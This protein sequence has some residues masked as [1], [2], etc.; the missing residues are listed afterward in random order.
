[1]DSAQLIHPT[2]D[3]WVNT[4]SARYPIFCRSGILNSDLAFQRYVED[5]PVLIVSHAN[6]ADLYGATIEQCLR[7]AN[8]RTVEQWLVPE[9]DA[10]KNLAQADKLWTRCLMQSYQRNLLMIALG[11]GMVGDLTGFCAS[12]YLRGVDFIQCPTTLLA[13]IDASIGGKTA[14]NHSLGK[15]LIGTFYQP[16]AVMVDPNVLHSLPAR[17]FN[18]GLAELIKYGLI[19]DADFFSWLEL[20]CVDLRHD[21]QK[22]QQAILQACKLK[23]YVVST[24]ERESN[25]RMILNFGHTVGHAI[26]NL[27]HY[28]GILHGEAVAIGMV[29]ATHLACEVNMLSYTVLERLV[30]LLR[31]IGLPVNIPPSI[32]VDAILEKIKL[33]KKN[34]NRLQ[35][36][37]LRELGSASINADVSA[38]TVKHILQQWV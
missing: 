35:W 23:A 24:D 21:S 3:L 9:G 30:T 18:A 17:E 28:Q 14:I 13:Q 12:T 36:V 32:Q 26:E 19:L 25:Q 10:H 4:D 15:N 7:R 22:C 37:L 2:P 29:V 1:M 27:M 33:D 38:R 8:A 20:N 31:S 16:L 6:V 5:R 34:I 11:G